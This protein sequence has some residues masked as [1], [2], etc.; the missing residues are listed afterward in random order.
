MIRRMWAAAAVLVLAATAPATAAPA[1]SRSTWP[2]TGSD[3]GRSFYNAG[4]DLLNASSIGRLKR[5]WSVPDATSDCPGRVGPVVAGGLTLTQD[6]AGL[7]ARDS[8][9]GRQVWRDTGIFFDRLAY[10]LVVS[11]TTVVVTS[12]DS[13][14]G[15]EGGDADGYV[16]AFD[17]ATGRLLWR[18]SPNTDAAQLIVTRGMV[19]VS[20][21]DYGTEPNVEAYRLTDGTPVWSDGDNT[22][23]RRTLFSPIPVGND[24]LITRGGVSRRVDAV[25]GNTTGSWSSTWTPLASYGDWVFVGD[26]ASWSLKAVR[27]STGRVAWSTAR[28]SS[29]VATD[30]RRLYL[31]SDTSLEAYDVTSGKR[32]WKAVLGAEVGQP[33]RA[34]GLIY[35]SLTG[36]PLAVRNAA[37]G[38]R[39][40]TVPQLSSLSAVAG[41]R[42][43]GADAKGLVVL[44]L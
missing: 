5:R 17:L 33:F 38:A 9:T 19:I 20:G 15:I 29:R 16:C 41:G 27:V 6:T 24:V 44:G 8:A 25:T 26:S 2:Q 4:E 35:V 42:L 7:V 39:V 12:S 28:V 14:C 10:H 21:N 43:A 11:G 32:A 18:R 31:A 34:G 40:T 30:G 13:L 22:D 36:K 37:T 3:A 1:D 23:G